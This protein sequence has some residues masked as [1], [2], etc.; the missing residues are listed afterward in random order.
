MF[1]NS[2]QKILIS[3]TIVH[4]NVLLMTK[5]REEENFIWTELFQS[6]LLVGVQFGLPV[7]IRMITKLIKGQCHK[8]SMVFN[9]TRCRF[10]Y[11]LKQ[12]TSIWF[13][14][15]PIPRRRMVIFKCRPYFNN[16][17]SINFVNTVWETFFFKYPSTHYRWS[18]INYEISH[19]S[20]FF[21]KSRNCTR[22]YTLYS[23]Q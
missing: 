14:I 13:G 19:F 12:L 11:R 20:L 21:K 1:D 7:S 18:Y 22:A 23:L 15:F 5:P 10:I 9:H 16:V 4:K 3:I 17:Y 6:Y 2:Q 8:K